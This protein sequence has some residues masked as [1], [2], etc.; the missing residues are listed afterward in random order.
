MRWSGKECAVGGG[1]A[2]LVA[3]PSGGRDA[4]WVAVRLVQL[5]QTLV[6]QVELP[7]AES[8]SVSRLPLPP[9]H[10]HLRQRPAPRHPA[11]LPTG[12]LESALRRRRESTSRPTIPGSPS[13]TAGLGT[14]PRLRPHRHPAHRPPTASRSLRPKVLVASVRGT[15]PPR[16]AAGGVSADH[17]CSRSRGR[18]RRPAPAASPSPGSARA[19]CPRRP[20]SPRGG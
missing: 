16:P 1:G 17:G 20:S 11:A 12:P 3:S 4:R 2:G 13:T 10:L 9:S 15:S 7:R 6:P 8:R 19:A 5:H 18:R 14:C